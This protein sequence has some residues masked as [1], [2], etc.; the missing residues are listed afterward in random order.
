MQPIAN[1][2]L[3][4]CKPGGHARFSPQPPFKRGQRTRD[5]EPRLGRDNGNRRQMRQPKPQRVYPAPADEVTNDDEHKAAHHERNDSKVQRKHS[6]RE[7]SVNQSV[8]RGRGVRQQSL[9]VPLTAPRSPDSGRDQRMPLV[10]T[11]QIPPVPGI[12][13]TI[14]DVMR[15]SCAIRQR[16]AL[17]R[18][19]A[20]IACRDRAAAACPPAP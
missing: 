20:K 4:I 17:A 9:I 16:A 7:L 8:C 10:E 5:S 18:T 19:D 11:V 6:I 15:N 1:K 3:A 14:S 2:T 12:N 13:T